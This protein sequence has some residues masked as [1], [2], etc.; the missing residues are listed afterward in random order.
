MM[1]LIVIDSWS[2]DSWF[3]FIAYAFLLS[4]GVRLLS[5]LLRAIELSSKPNSPAYFTCCWQ[6]LLGYDSDPYK[7]DYWFPFIL[8][9]L[10]FL[11]YPFLIK[12][13]LWGGIAVWISLKTL[14]Q[15]EI[16][17]S[18][19]PVFNRFLI[20]N[21]IVILLSLVIMSRMVSVTLNNSE[22]L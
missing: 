14:P 10:E 22:S 19:R 8:G 21:A 16:W 20:G 17:K 9:F 2:V 7:A 5:S 11:V 6:S 18:N 4:I 15:W 13:G 3:V 1:K 12:A